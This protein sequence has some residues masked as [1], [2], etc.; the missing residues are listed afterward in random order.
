MKVAI[1]SSGNT[2][3]ALLDQRFGRC[4]YFAFYDTESKQLE[5][6]ENTNKD[7]AEGAGPASV[8]TVANHK[9]TKI[10]SGEFGFKI[11]GMLNDL[12]IQMVMIKEHKTVQ[13]IINLLEQ[14]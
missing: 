7:A 14:K 6:V 4:A 10:I 8:A 12:N 2:V 13:D 3:D 9:V 5:F 11:K 1:T